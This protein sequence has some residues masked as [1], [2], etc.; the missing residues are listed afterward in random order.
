MFFVGALGPYLTPIIT[1]LIP[2]VMIIS[3][4]PGSVVP[5]ESIELKQTVS[6]VSTYIIKSEKSV[7]IES[8]AFRLKKIHYFIE[9]DPP[10]LRAWGKYRFRCITGFFSSSGNKAP[11]WYS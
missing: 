4:H 5:I 6:V 11:P 8:D 1:L 7:G 3:I 10:K 9:P 2:L